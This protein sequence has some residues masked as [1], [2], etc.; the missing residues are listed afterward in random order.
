M[1]NVVVD[2]VKSLSWVVIQGKMSH[3]QTLHHMSPSMFLL[4]SI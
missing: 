4:L 2:Q 3:N 1:T